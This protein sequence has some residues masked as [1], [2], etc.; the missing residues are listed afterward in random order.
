MSR[1]IAVLLTLVFIAGLLIC[2]VWRPTS[3]L[4]PIEVVGPSMA[5]G[6]RGAHLD[7]TC[8]DCGY[9]FST[10][11]PEGSTY[12]QAVLCPN[13]GYPQPGSAVGVAQP[14]DRLLVDTEAFLH[15]RPMRWETVVFRS[16]EEPGTHCIK[17]VVGLPGESVE[18][19]E[20]KVW[21]DGAP[22]RKA[23]A[24]QRQL[25][26]P[27]YDSRF[28]PHRAK[29]TPDRWRPAQEESDWAKAGDGFRHMPRDAIDW[30]DYAHWQRA[31]GDPAHIRMAPVTDDD[32]YNVESSRQLNEVADLMLV[33][34]LRTVG[35]GK[36]FLRAQLRGEHFQIELEPLHGSGRLLHDATAVAGTE[37][38]AGAPLFAEPSL[39][40]FSLIDYQIAL[41]INQREL[42]R[43]AIP[44][45]TA[46]AGSGPLRPLGIGAAGLD[47]QIESLQVLRDI[48]YTRPT[49]TGG[50]FGDGRAFKLGTSEYFFLGDNSPVSADCRQGL[51]GGGLAGK[52]LTGR[53]GRGIS[54][55]RFQTSD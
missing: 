48:Y 37:F 25:A 32:A 51:P 44:T 43:Y 41:A 24:E 46:A 9:R 22:L 55:F 3:H 16:P 40:E 47:V 6:L 11:P 39:L 38:N 12:T 27:V 8:A 14:G 42:I 34:R 18:I 10:A 35:A 4:Q 1:R 26:V 30:L 5:P 23:L 28:R 20:G 33:A 21:I 49:G 7:W 15:H 2:A 19:R 29:D 17:R 45:P 53:P 13:C 52:Y 54:D 50:R 36:L 31:P